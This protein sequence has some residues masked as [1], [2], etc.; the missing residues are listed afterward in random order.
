MKDWL[1]LA[2]LT[3]CL[4]YLRCGAGAG[5]EVQVVRETIWS[6]GQQTVWWIVGVLLMQW[7][8]CQGRSG[9]PTTWR[10]RWCWRRP[11]QLASRLI[12]CSWG[13]VSSPPCRRVADTSRWDSGQTISLVRLSSESIQLSTPT[14]WRCRWVVLEAAWS[15]CQQTSWWIFCVLSPLYDMKVQ[16]VLEAAWSAD[17]MIDCL[18]V[19]LWCRCQGRSGTPTTWRC[20]WCWRQPGQLASRQLTSPSTSPAVRTLWTSAI[21]PKS[22]RLPAS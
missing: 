3:D 9:T 16:V 10:C 4:Y 12:T 5:G 19:L 13:V 8:R 21:S 6:A 14:T 15:A 1:F 18:Y 20:R 2:G 17:W 7:C 11:G 22:G